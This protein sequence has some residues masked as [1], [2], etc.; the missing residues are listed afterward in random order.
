MEEQMA[1]NL[2]NYRHNTKTTASH[3]SDA[4]HRGLPADCRSCAKPKG[5]TLIELMVVI[6]I[7]GVILIVAIPNFARMQQRARVRAGAQEVAQDFRQI[8]ERALSKGWK[9]R[10]T[11]LDMRNYQVTNPQGNVSTYRLGSTA[12]GNLRFGVSTSYAGGVPPEANQAAAP[13][14]GFDFLG[15]EL[16]FDNRGGANRGVLYITDEREDYAIGVN[17]LGKVKGYRY[18]NGSWN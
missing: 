5:F 6:G 15:G 14:D 7:I 9:F 8:R 13:T 3:F 12:G 11:R 2:Q 16:I 18:E 17:N 4:E 10:I 1:K